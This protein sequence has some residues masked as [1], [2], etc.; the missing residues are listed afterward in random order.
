M[1]KRIAIT[2]PEST[3]KTWLAE[4]LAAHYSANIV[5]EFAREYFQNRK[6]EYNE[7]DL[8]EIAIGQLEKEENIASISGNI[9]F[10]DT[11][12]LVI[13]IWSTVVFGIVPEW[14]EKQM[15]EH[16]YDLYLL[17]YPDVKWQ[18]DP[19]RS[20]PHDRQYI[21]DLFVKELEQHN[22]NYR[23]VK[24]ISEK[25]FKNAVNFVDELLEYDNKS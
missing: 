2:G 22:L 20:N 3:G 19:L 21:Y 12:L 16:V 9:I 5:S 14:I 13:K 17:C 23:V 4:K 10:C 15:S 8:V 6:Y 1:L 18:P 7:D 24:G 25:R 11:D